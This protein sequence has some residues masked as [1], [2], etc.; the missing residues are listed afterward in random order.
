MKQEILL[1]KANTFINDGA[2]IRGLDVSIAAT[3]QA[4]LMNIGYMLSESAYNT[5]AST[6]SNCVARTLEE[7][8][9]ILNKFRGSNVKHKPM[10]KNFPQ[11]VIEMSDA[12]LYINAFVHYWSFGTWMPESEEVLRDYG[13]EATKYTVLDCVDERE[14]ESKIGDLINSIASSKESISDTDKTYLKWYIDE[15]RPLGQIDFQYK[16]NMCFVAGAL[17]EAGKLDASS[18]LRTPTDILRFV[19]YLSDGDISLA[20]NCKFKSLSRKLRRELVTALEQCINN[21]DIARHAGKWKRL[22]HSLH[23]GEYSKVAPKTHVLARKVRGNKRI[24]TFNGKVEAA[25][26]DLDVIN[27]VELLRQRPGDFHRRLDHLLRTFVQDNDYI[28]DEY[29]GVVDKVPPRLLIQLAGH[30]RQRETSDQMYVFPK[31]ATQRGLIVA[32]KGQLD[33]ET[34]SRL[35]IIARTALVRSFEGRKELGKVW[36]D[37]NLMDCPLPTQ[38]RS[39]SEGLV[40]LARGTKFEMGTKNFLRFF[41]YWKGQDIDLS[42]TFHDEHF[43]L[44]D[45]VSYTNLRSDGPQVYHSGDITRAPNGA[46]EYIDVEV[47]KAVKCGY[48]YV[49]MNVYVFSGPNFKDHEEVFAGWMSLDK[50]KQNKQFQPKQVQQRIDL[51]AETRNMVPVVFDLKERKVIWTDIQNRPNFKRHPWGG[52]INS[53]ETN[54][55]GIEKSLELIANRADTQFTLYELFASHAVARGKVVDNPEDADVK[56]GFTTEEVECDV[57]P[58]DI[59]IINSE[60]I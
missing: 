48:R 4:E 49:V 33:R 40:E 24:S 41:V 22:F 50:P 31:G 7:I 16:E 54:Q 20:S 15:G 13:F 30:L 60:F 46:T 25:I 37:P 58:F 19:T 28:L 43:N 42:A 5:I 52:R 55:I 29:E 3:V 59:N 9:P 39:A 51:T 23:I 12:E 32:R 26:K 45:Q 8:L 57:T 6:D 38:Q 2:K 11:E 18:I 53:V 34:I 14:A 35:D 56:F 36:I 17:Y 44:V 47:D 21:D 1:R 27:A 10:Y